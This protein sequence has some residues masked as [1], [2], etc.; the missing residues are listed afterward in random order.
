MNESYFHGLP[1]ITISP[2]GKDLARF[3]RVVCTYLGLANGCP[4]APCRRARA[5]ATR[6]VICWQHCRDYINPLIRVGLAHAWRQRVANGEAQDVS[7][8]RAAQYSRLLAD[9]SQVRADVMARLDEA[10]AARDR[11][12]SGVAEMVEGKFA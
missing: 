4:F 10:I 8:E 6:E 9:E 3:L 5:C 12:L 11:A 7:P 2:L 1:P